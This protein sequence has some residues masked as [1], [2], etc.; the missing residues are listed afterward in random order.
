MTYV[1]CPC[2]RAV[3]KTPFEAGCGVLGCK[4]VRQL[5][6]T[7]LRTVLAAHYRNRVDVFS[8]STDTKLTHIYA[9]E[10]SHVLCHT[11]R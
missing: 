9:G 5:P 2:R 6:N 3:I 8:V 7:F 4:Q 11:Q 1:D 10:F